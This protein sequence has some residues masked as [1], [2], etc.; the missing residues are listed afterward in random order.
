[1]AGSFAI[2]PSLRGKVVLITGGGSGI[3]AAMVEH[4]VRQGA[5]V[6]FLDIDVEASRALVARLVDDGEEGQVRPLFLRCDLR[7]IDALRD[8]IAGVS[9]TLGRIDVLVNNAANDDRHEIEAIEPAYFDDRMAINLRHQVFAAQAVLADMKQAGG[10]SIINMGSISWV[11]GEPDLPLY[12]AAKAAVNGLTRSLARKLGP[13]G[14]RVNC[15]MPGWIMT[16]RQR[17]LWLTPAGEAEIMDRQALK[18][19]LYPPDVARMV[20][21][22]AAEDSRLCTG[23]NFVV[24]GGWT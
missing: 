23:Q 5:R 8:V 3:G 2:Y 17:R 24:D 13:H 1:M 14:I 11:I 4:F 22:L 19:K 10:G 21:W 7:D 20:L 18:E 9:E 15:V 16:E 6:A 12:T